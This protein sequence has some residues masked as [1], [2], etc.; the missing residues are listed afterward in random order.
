MLSR[1][2]LTYHMDSAHP[3]QETPPRGAQYRRARLPTPSQ[4]RLCHLF[5]IREAPQL[6]AR[7]VEICTMT[8]DQERSIRQRM[9]QPPVTM[10]DPPWWR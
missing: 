8:E 10:I 4:E 2:D 3:D 6:P 1:P 5:T 9:A 7:I